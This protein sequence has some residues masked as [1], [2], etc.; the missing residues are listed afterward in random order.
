MN[1]DLT[2][3][4]K[5]EIVKKSVSEEVR[6]EVTI[7]R[8]GTNIEYRTIAALFGLGRSTACEIVLDTCEVIDRHLM[9]RYVRVSQNES[10]RE[11]IDGFQL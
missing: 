8:L 10:F 5:E 1:S 9:P 11:I 7:W 4:K 6:V 3:K 2:L